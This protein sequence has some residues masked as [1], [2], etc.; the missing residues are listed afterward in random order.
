MCVCVC[1]KANLFLSDIL[2]NLNWVCCLWFAHIPIWTHAQDTELYHFY[3]ALVLR[4][5]F[6]TTLKPEREGKV[7][8][9]HLIFRAFSTLSLT[10]Y[11]SHFLLSLLSLFF[12]LLFIV[13]LVLASSPTHIFRNIREHHNN[14]YQVPVCGMIYSHFRVKF[15]FYKDCANTLFRVPETASHVTSKNWCDCP[16]W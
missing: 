3:I 9:G 12:Y 10:I 16:Q 6:C 5:Y 2:C 1:V 4:E 7:T 14:S 8:F 11:V 15:V 13:L